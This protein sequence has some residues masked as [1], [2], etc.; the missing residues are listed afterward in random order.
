MYC[1]SGVTASHAFVALTIAGFE[2]VRAGRIALGGQTLS[3]PSVHLPP[4]RRR[5]GMMFQE[6]AL[7]PHLSAAQN[8]AFGLRRS[9]RAAQA[10]RSPQG[11]V[12]LPTPPSV[13]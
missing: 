13:R 12:R 7:F 2:P 3:S 11:G 1:G 10:A 8:V 5:V 4:E 9:P 6:Y